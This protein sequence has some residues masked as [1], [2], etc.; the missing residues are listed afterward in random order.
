MTPARKPAHRLR[1]AL[2]ALLCGVGLTGA[3]AQ[4]RGELLYLTHCEACHTAQVHWRDDRQVVDWPS[5]RAQVRR[6]QS[7]DRLAWPDDDI[8]AV[9]Q[10]LNALFYH[11]PP[12]PSRAVV[13]ALP[14]AA[15]R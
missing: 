7:A 10:Y 3:W 11:L 1:L 13:S 5:L 2:S 8:E 9:A 6:W 4:T 15:R 12:P 14:V